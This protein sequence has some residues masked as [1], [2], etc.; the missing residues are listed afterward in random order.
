MRTPAPLPA[1]RQ[2]DEVA[3]P[4]RGGR[5]SGGLIGCG[6]SFSRSMRAASLGSTAANGLGL[7][8][9]RPRLARERNRLPQAI[10]GHRPPARRGRRSGRLGY[11]GQVTD[12][13]VAPPPIAQTVGGWWVALDAEFSARGM[14]TS[15]LRLRKTDPLPASVLLGPLFGLSPAVGGRATIHPRCI[16]AFTGLA[17][18]AFADAT[19]VPIE[20][21]VATASAE[22]A[23]LILD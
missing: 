19:A 6:V 10:A 16:A 7:L 15:K 8:K 18:V 14:G 22:G 23:V 11:R 20:T 12:A 13:R 21:L 17:E 3:S 1:G 5:L 9:V 4:V 2:S